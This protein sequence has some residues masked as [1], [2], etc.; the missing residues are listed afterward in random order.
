[1]RA[2]RIDATPLRIDG[3]L[4]GVRRLVRRGGPA[5]TEQHPHRRAADGPDDAW[6]EGAVVRRPHDVSVDAHVV[7]GARARMQVLDDH[8]RVV[9]ASDGERP[10][11]MTEHVDVA[12]A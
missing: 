2:E 11:A 12:R 4:E 6:R 3:H 7:L 9:M 8:E 1:V 10:G 5:R